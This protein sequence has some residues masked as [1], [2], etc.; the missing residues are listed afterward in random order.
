MLPL[1][2]W[3]IWNSNEQL[4][5]QLIFGE[6]QAK[7]TAIYIIMFALYTSVDFSSSKF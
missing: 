5:K 2:L 6:L 4:R 3:N 7:K 1:L